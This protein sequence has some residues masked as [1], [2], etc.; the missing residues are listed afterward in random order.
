MMK[1]PNNI[2]LPSSFNFQNLFQRKNQPK[3]KK[4]QKVFFQHIIFGAIV[5]DFLNNIQ[6]YK[7]NV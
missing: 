5:H 6:F 4:L 3:K 1:K 2:I 7:L